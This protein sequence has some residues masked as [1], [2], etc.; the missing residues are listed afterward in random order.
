M[1]FMGKDNVPFHTIIFPATQL[2]T[3]DAWTKMKRIS[4]TEYLTYEGTKFS[5]S[6]NTGVFGNDAFDTGIPPEVS[7]GHFH[8]WI[9]ES[10]SF[11]MQIKGSLS[12]ASC[13]VQYTGWQVYC[14]CVSSVL[15]DS[16]VQAFAH[17][18][19]ICFA[20]CRCLGIT[21]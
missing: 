13:W 11:R 9:K 7:L 18:Q 21:C 10:H 15:S 4:V 3:R 5:K 14:T 6:R 8:E 16:C 1:Q 19:R 2:A 20:G 17:M 12:L